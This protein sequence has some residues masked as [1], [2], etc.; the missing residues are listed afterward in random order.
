MRARKI[1][2]HGAGVQSRFGGRRVAAVT[3]PG[4][5]YRES[6]RG[7]LES[8]SDKFRFC[9]RR[10]NNLTDDAVYGEEVG[11]GTGGEKDCIWTLFSLRA[12]LHMSGVESA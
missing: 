11:T 5:N 10:G 7:M 9:K 1:H 8:G 3:R 4:R 2:M 6:C 12:D